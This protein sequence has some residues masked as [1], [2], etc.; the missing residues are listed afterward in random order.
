M[1]IVFEA[2][3]L[4]SVLSDK[5]GCRVLKLKNKANGKN[6]ILRSFSQRVPAYEQLYAVCCQNLPLV[7]DVID[8]DD[9][10]IVLEEFIDGVTVSEVME[11]GYYRYVG[12]RRV[13]RSVCNALNVLHGIKYTFQ[14]F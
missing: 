12:A 8:L 3:S 14:M 9:G 2:F 10:Q 4:V 11:S 7:Y 5:N 1:D 13:L 6:V